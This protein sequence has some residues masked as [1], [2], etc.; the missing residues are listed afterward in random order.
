MDNEM[1]TGRK[2]DEVFVAVIDEDVNDK[3]EQHQEQHQ[4]LLKQAQ[5]NHDE[6][7]N[8]IKNN[9]TETNQEQEQPNH[10]QENTDV[11]VTKVLLPSRI[12]FNTLVETFGEKESFLLQYHI[13]PF[14]GH[15]H[16]RFVA[17]VNHQM[18]YSYEYFLRNQQKQQQQDFKKNPH[19]NRHR[20]YL[21]NSITTTTGAN[22]FGSTSRA[23]LYMAEN[24]FKGIVANKRNPTL[25]LNVA[26]RGN[27]EL[28]QSLHSE[29][30]WLDTKLPSK[31]HRMFSNKSGFGW[32]AGKGGN[33]EILKWAESAL[34]GN[35]WETDFICDGAAYA[36]HLEVLQWA[37]NKGFAWSNKTCCN[38]AGN[39]HLD[40][41]K[42]AT[43]NGC[44]WD[45][46]TCS[47]AAYNGHLD[48]LK[49]ARENGCEWDRKHCVVLAMRGGH[50]GVVE[51]IMRQS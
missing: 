24:S 21:T 12:D 30:Y 28:L 22:I 47:G 50:D 2:I 11:D 1:K 17:G 14:L 48:I 25:C 34:A 6:Q 37:R 10:H 13:F 33:L 36:G 32:Y 44:E 16:Y 29:G 41:L 40:I 9:H 18:K 46:L 49:W 38:A 39:G 19:K 26:L 43:Q 27:L 35:D 31:R 42:W 5:L 3:Q 23:R 51:W 45:Y 20:H 8:N 4:D 15:G 7:N